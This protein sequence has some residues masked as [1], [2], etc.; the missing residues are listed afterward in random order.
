M[1]LMYVEIKLHK[2]PCKVPYGLAQKA[3]KGEILKKKNF[4]VHSF[5]MHNLT[6]ILVLFQPC[7]LCPFK[8]V[9]L[10]TCTDLASN[11]YCVDIKN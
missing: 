4:L 9:Q 10:A 3:I 2:V 6:Y 8:L 5:N 7:L 11:S 1:N